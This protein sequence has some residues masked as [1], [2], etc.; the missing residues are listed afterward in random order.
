MQFYNYR[1]WKLIFYFLAPR[2]F[3]SLLQISIMHKKVKMLHLL[4]VKKVNCYSSLLLLLSQVL[5]KLQLSNLLGIQVSVVILCL[6]VLEG[7]RTEQEL[8]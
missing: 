7:E 4:T 2:N 6:F 8:N 3:H 1:F 5:K